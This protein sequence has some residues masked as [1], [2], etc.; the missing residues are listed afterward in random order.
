MAVAGHSQPWL[1]TSLVESRSLRA[2]RL[3]LPPSRHVSHL[4]VGPAASRPRRHGNGALKAEGAV[5]G[6]CR[7]GARQPCGEGLQPLL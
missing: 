1:S 7:H 6:G 2:A 3:G 4:R 5:M